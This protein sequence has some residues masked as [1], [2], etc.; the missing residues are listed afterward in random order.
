MTPLRFASYGGDSRYLCSLPQSLRYPFP[1]Y[2]PRLAG[3]RDQFRD[4]S[5]FRL[6]E[7][8]YW[9]RKLHDWAVFAQILV[10]VDPTECGVVIEN[11]F[12]QIS[13]WSSGEMAVDDFDDKQHAKALVRYQ[14]ISAYIAMDPP[15]GQR[16]AMLEHLASRTWTGPDGEPFQVAAETIRSWVR[17]YRQGGLDALRDKTR[18]RRGA[19]AMT[20]AQVELAS[21]LKQEVLERSLNKLITIME[22]VGAVEPGDVRRST[23]HRRLQERGLSRRAS[24]VPDRPQTSTG[25]R[26]RSSTIFG[27]PTF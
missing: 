11:W 4:N 16:R 21:R 25:S 27:S 18:A 1:S 15:R 9:E 24:R 13:R 23:L 17:R 2:W 26:P 22:A 5:K 12:V 20:D 19:S 6:P 7:S 3:G 14:V 8:P 10:A